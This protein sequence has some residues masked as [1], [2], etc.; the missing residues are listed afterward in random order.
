M[1]IKFGMLNG[2]G[3]I[4]GISAL[5]LI[6]PQTASGQMLLMIIVISLVNGL[7]GVL[8]RSKLRRE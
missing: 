1:L 4:L 7:G 5:Y 8:W 3:L 6:E 2:L